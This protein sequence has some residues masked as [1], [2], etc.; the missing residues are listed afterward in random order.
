[1]E[2]QEGRRSGF[3]DI[4]L[5]AI[6]IL[7]LLVWCGSFLYENKTSN[8]FL[9]PALIEYGFCVQLSLVDK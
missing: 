4:Y 5:F 2:I 1:V 7:S 6:H 8:N 9:S 3:G